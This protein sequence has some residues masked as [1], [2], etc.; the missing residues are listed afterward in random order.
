MPV[1]YKY[2]S[3]KYNITIIISKKYLKISTA[4]IIYKF[5]Y[6]DIKLIDA[7][8][9]SLLIETIKKRYEFNAESTLI[10]TICS[11]TK[12]IMRGESLDFIC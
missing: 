6:S 11:S 4:Q 12:K 8:S 2:K 10:Y 9:E 5:K 1:A 7:F 3:I